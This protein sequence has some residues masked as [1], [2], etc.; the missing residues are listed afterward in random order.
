MCHV[1]TR[2]KC[3]ASLQNWTQKTS[4]MF[5]IPYNFLNGFELISK[6][7]RGSSQLAEIRR[8]AWKIPC[9][10]IWM[11]SHCLP[12]LLS[13]EWSP[14]IPWSSWNHPRLSWWGWRQQSRGPGPKGTLTTRLPQS[15]SHGTGQKLHWL[16][17]PAGVNVQTA[18]CHR[19]GVGRM[20]CS[21]VIYGGKY[22]LYIELIY[23]GK[24]YYN[25]NYELWC[26]NYMLYI[27][28]I[29]GAKYVLQTEWSNMWIHTIHRQ[30]Q[31]MV[32]NMSY[33]QKKK[34]WEYIL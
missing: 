24:Y 32:R 27:E 28:M 21:R 19:P 9:L 5:N 17:L 11:K 13:H 29:Y 31:S 1:R 12:A 15:T 22:V 30:N 6:M 3:E 10:T 25:R 16:P 33:R 18:W 8:S 4:H 2:L 20:C 14:S 23:G 26:G 7:T 34:W